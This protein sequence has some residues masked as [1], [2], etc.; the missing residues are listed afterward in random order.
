VSSILFVWN[1]AGFWSIQSLWGFAVSLPVTLAMSATSFYPKSQ[2]PRFGVYGCICTGLIATGLIIETVSDRQKWNFKS[3]LDNKKKFCNVG[4]WKYSRHPNYFGDILFWC[5][6]TALTLPVIRHDLRLV[7]LALLS[8]FLTMTLLL[9]V[10][11]I[12]MLEKQHDSKYGDDEEYI[13]WKSNT[14]ILVP[15]PPFITDA[16]KID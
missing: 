14:S 10:S 16:K 12:P 7:A 6:M 15:L 9:G 1:L 3:K 2:L 4:L 5:S 11:G 13:R 8:P